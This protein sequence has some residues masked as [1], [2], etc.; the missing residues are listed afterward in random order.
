MGQTAI[1]TVQISVGEEIEVYLNEADIPTEAEEEEEETEET[2]EEEETGNTST[3]D[4]TNNLCTDYKVLEV[5]YTLY[6]SDT[7][8]LTGGT[9]DLTFTQSVITDSSIS[10]K[11]SV[12]FLGSSSGYVRSGNPGYI[13]GSALGIKSETGYDAQSTFTLSGVE[14]GICA[15]AA[16]EVYVSPHNQITINYG[17]DLLVMCKVPSADLQDYCA[18]SQLLASANLVHF[19]AQFAN[20]DDAMNGVTCLSVFCNYL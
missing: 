19:I 5:A 9:V 20:P 4:S 1:L 3:W 17:E 8:T 11:F 6:I 14:D 13:K 15:S 18:S 16:S 7:L 2:E 12:K 10:Q